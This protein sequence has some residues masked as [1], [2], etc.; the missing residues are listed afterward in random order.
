[1]TSISIG[2]RKYSDPDVL[3]LI[4]SRPGGVDPRAEVVRRARELHYRL[5][6]LGEFD[7]PRERLEALASL[8]GIKTAPMSVTAIGS[9]K[10]E[11]LIYRD[12]DGTKRAF[13]DPTPPAGRVNFSI[14]H[15]IIHTFFPNSGTGARFRSITAADSRE[16]NELERLCDLGAAELVMPADEFHEALEGEFGLGIV[17]RLAARFG[18]SYEATVYRLASAATGVAVAGLLR[19]RLRKNE[20]RSSRQPSLFG[21]HKVVRPA[22]PK[23]RRQSLYSSD[24]CTDEHLIRWN[25]SFEEASCVYRAHESNGIVYGVEQLPNSTGAPGLIEAVIAPFQRVNSDSSL[26]DVLFIWWEE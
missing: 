2:G 24:I 26:P 23:Y 6:N 10:R 22:T 5:R 4:R 13:F 1:M 8:A 18:T 21:N 17:P 12:T 3:S 11:A 19:H 9:A 20:V 14:A 25:K 16:A 7:N 15:E